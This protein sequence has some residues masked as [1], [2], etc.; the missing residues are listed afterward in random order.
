MREEEEEEGTVRYIEAEVGGGHFLSYEERGEG[1]TLHPR[2]APFKK[3]VEPQSPNASTSKVDLRRVTT[4]KETSIGTYREQHFTQPSP[5]SSQG[6]RSIAV[7][8]KPR[9]RQRQKQ[10]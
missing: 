4:P 6:W 8:S 5:P 10:N 7:A 2:S 1:S 3:T 9:E